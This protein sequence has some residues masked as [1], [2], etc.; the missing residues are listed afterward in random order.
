MT[1]I[2]GSVVR[3]LDWAIDSSV[4]ATAPLAAPHLVA[5]K[6]RGLDRQAGTWPRK[7]RPRLPYVVNFP[8]DFVHILNLAQGVGPAHNFVYEWFQFFLF[9]QLSI[10][11]LE[12]GCEVDVRMMVRSQM[13]VQSKAKEFQHLTRSVPVVTEVPAGSGKARHAIE[14]RGADIPSHAGRFRAG[15]IS[16]VTRLR[17][18]QGNLAAGLVK[19]DD[20]ILTHDGKPSAVRWVGHIRFKSSKWLTEGACPV[21]IL[22]GALGGGLPH[23][24][25]LVSAEQTVLLSSPLVERISGKREAFARA[26]DLTHLPGVEIVRVS[27]AVYVCILLDSHDF[28]S[29]EGVGLGSF[30]PDSAVTQ[31]FTEQLRNSLFSVAPALRYDGGAATYVETRPQLNQREVRLVL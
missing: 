30:R 25:L 2:P 7:N 18:S 1:P 8:E 17:T 13:N 14:L 31:C 19:R 9:G 24:D 5:S 16:P 29:A 10:N 26:G 27:W 28:L 12:L 15:C 21:R 3:L 11:R 23:H 20:L 4:I 6:L 22:A